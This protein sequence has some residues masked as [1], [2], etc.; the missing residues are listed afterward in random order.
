MFCLR[1]EILCLALLYL[2]ARVRAYNH[3][4]DG[5]MLLL[6]RDGKGKGSV[7]V[8]YEGVD[9][10]LMSTQGG[11]TRGGDG[12]YIYLHLFMNRSRA[13]QIIKGY[14]TLSGCQISN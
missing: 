9:Q 13:E 7:K 1:F 12:V 4:S 6:K 2:R 3:I 5:R 10:I 14:Q 11:A 8:L